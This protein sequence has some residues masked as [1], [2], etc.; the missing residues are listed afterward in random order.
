MAGIDCT[1]AAAPPLSSALS[2]CAE[3]LFSSSITSLMPL[4]PAL[5]AM[6]SRSDASFASVGLLLPCESQLD[7]DAAF[8]LDTVLY[9]QQKGGSLRPTIRHYDSSL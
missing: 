8:E 4:H 7:A 3:H 5:A 6:V 1:N 9:C 2:K